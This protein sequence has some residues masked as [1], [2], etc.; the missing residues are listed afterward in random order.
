MPRTA[1]TISAGGC[2]HVLNRGNAGATVFHDHA[3]Y[4][5]FLRLASRATERTPLHIFGY[6]I[7]PTHFH[8]VVSPAENDGLARWM[9]WLATTFA[10]RYHRRHTSYGRIWQGR[11]KVFP[12]QDDAH[13]TTVLRYVERNALRA[14]LV[15]RA[16]HWRWG[17]LRQRVGGRQHLPL[18]DPPTPLPADWIERVNEA[19]F[20]HEYQAFQRSLKRGSPFGDPAWTEA[21]A[22][23]L[24]LGSALR[25]RGRPRKGD[26]NLKSLNS[27]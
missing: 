5:L 10:H 25:K 21:C 16:E 2:Y 14:E 26:K 1:R 22:V 18:C 19:E 3:D 7:M 15:V 17:S 23:E 11:F 24:G 12:I 4:Q 20:A 9:H 8:F 27:G 6:C 13:L